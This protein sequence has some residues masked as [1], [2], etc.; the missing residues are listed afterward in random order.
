MEI[1][2]HNIA[3]FTHIE[4]TVYRGSAGRGI[5]AGRGCLAHLLLLYIKVAP[6]I[7]RAPHPLKSE[8]KEQSFTC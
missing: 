2:Q 4:L 8:I 6:R 1:Q 3:H 5:D 7:W